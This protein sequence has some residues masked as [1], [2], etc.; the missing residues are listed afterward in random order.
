MRNVPKREQLAL[1]GFTNPATIPAPATYDPEAY[2]WQNP[3]A[4]TT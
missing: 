1:H 4:H 2:Y 3:G